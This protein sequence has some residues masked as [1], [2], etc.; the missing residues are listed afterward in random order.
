[1]NV[2]IFLT[3]KYY[4]CAD[5]LRAKDDKSIKR[6]YHPFTRDDMD[7]ISL[8]WSFPFYSSF[9]IRFLFGWFNI[10]IAAAVCSLAVVG[11]GDLRNLSS[12]RYKII[13]TTVQFYS[14]IGLKLAG[15]TSMDSKEV[16]ID[17]SSFLGPEWKPEYEGA[18]TLVSKHIS[19]MDMLAAVVLYFPAFTARASGRNMPLLGNIMESMSTIFIQRIGEDLKNQKRVALDKI[20]QH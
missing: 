15:Y 19:W 8:F 9:I 17:Y 6:K 10:L 1:M 5:L 16:Y 14:F 4:F 18:S 3:G 2:I 11:A 12:W 20:Q 7:R 13:K